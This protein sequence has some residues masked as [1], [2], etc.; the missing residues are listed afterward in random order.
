MSAGPRRTREARRVGG[1]S[2][3]SSGSSRPCAWAAK[4]DLTLVSRVSGANGAGGQRRLVLPERVRRTAA[5]SR[6][7]RT[8]PTS[9]ARTWTRSTDVF[10]RDLQTNVLD[11][12]PAA[13]P[14]PAGP[15]G[16]TA[17]RT[18]RSR[19][20][21]ATW[22]SS[23]NADN[24][25]A[26][27]DNTYH[28]RVRPRP[29]GEHDHAGEPRRRGGRRRRRTTASYDARI[30]ADG[31]YVDV[32]LGRG[33]P[34]RRG[35][36]HLHQHLRPRPPG[37]HDDTREPGDGGGRHRGRRR[38]RSTRRSRRTGGIVAFQSSANN[39]SAGGQQHLLQH[40]RPRPP[41]ERR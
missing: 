29:P 18:R 2:Q 39:L 27:D 41:G 9:A 6:S 26:E 32:L 37:E 20:T 33:Q 16:P 10:V 3:R 8:P 24:L 38:A 4:D 36:Q 12:R 35:Q 22:P 19:P 40:L 1:A 30:S 11:P 5:T 21:A 28:E 15:A 25:S 34:Q 17:R 7:T 31:R 14:A 13:P 23:S